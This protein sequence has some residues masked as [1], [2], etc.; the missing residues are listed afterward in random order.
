[1][2]SE[3]SRTPGYET[4]SHDKIMLEENVGMEELRFDSCRAF[5]S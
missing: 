3:S 2:I 5:G 1:M 4:V